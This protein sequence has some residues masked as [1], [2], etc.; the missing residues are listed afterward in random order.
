MKD[1]HEFSM[2]NAAHTHR[3]RAIF[4][5]IVSHSADLSLKRLLLLRTV[6]WIKGLERQFLTILDLTLEQ[7]VQGSI[8]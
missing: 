8:E 1:A 2:C 7:L 4:K 5:R 3:G 6:V